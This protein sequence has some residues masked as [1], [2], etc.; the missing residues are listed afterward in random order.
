[1][2]YKPKVCFL[3]NYHKKNRSKLLYLFGEIHLNWSV[4]KIFIDS[5]ISENILNT[6][7]FRE[8]LE[9]QSVRKLKGAPKRIRYY[10]ESD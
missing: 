9:K 2:R 1:M 3:S 7:K 10:K 8:A 5:T 6:D 4:D